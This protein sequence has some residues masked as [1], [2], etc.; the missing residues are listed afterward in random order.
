MALRNVGVAGGLCGLHCLSNTRER[1][2]PVLC[3]CCVQL[4]ATLDML[5]NRA[6]GVRMERISRMGADPRPD[7][8]IR[9]DGVSASSPC[10]RDGLGSPSRI[11]ADL[12]TCTGDSGSSVKCGGGSGGV[13]SGV[14]LT[15]QVKL[16]LPPALPPTTTLVSSSTT[17]VTTTDPSELPSPMRARRSPFRCVRSVTCILLY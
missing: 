9:L 5:R 13:D 7:C 4:P 10:S 12:S 15:Q 14:V 1:V 6:V 3:V 2:V 8:C 16:C 17:T 11:T